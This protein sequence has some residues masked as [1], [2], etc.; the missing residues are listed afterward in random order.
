[1]IPADDQLPDRAL[2]QVT[3]CSRMWGRFADS[4]RGR[5]V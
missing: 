5:T 4:A 1:M 3:M 2:P